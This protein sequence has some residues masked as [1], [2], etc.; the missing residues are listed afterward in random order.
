MITTIKMWGNSQAVRL[1]KN[2]LNSLNISVDDEL[3]ISIEDDKI[4]LEKVKYRHM[5]IQ[6]RFEKYDSKCN[7][8]EVD[9]R[10]PEGKEIW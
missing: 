10:K 6:E 5:T 9:R 1:P 2:L 8:E 4:V 3:Q 7:E